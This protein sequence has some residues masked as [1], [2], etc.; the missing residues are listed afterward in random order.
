ME[1]CWVSLGTA[2]GNS[3]YVN[4]N[5]EPKDTSPHVTWPKKYV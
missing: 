1:Q 2:A 3:M 4:S 5:S